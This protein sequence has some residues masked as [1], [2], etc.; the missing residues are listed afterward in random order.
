MKSKYV[1]THDLLRR[2]FEE[3]SCWVA[4]LY[5]NIDTT[6]R[7]NRNLDFD[8]SLPTSHYLYLRSKYY[9]ELLILSYVNLCSRI[10]K[11]TIKIFWEIYYLHINNIN[12]RAFLWTNWGL[13]SDIAKSNFPFGRDR[14][15]LFVDKRNE[16]IPVWVA[17]HTKSRLWLWLWLFT[18]IFTG[19]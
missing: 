14:R 8:I 16:S 13:H 2:R 17:L 10:A 3:H 18:R 1:N 5:T 9:F 6:S 15:T 19:I 4:L 11:K 7:E 12:L